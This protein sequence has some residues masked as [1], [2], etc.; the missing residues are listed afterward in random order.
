VYETEGTEAT[1]ATIVVAKPVT[2]EA[3][4]PPMS[5]D[6]VVAVTLAVDEETATLTTQCADGSSVQGTPD[7]SPQ[8]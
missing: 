8:G 1:S 5:V 4:T 3:A 2:E 6:E 7:E